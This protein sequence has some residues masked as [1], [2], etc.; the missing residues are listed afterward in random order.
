MKATIHGA[1][2]FTE[3][4]WSAIDR[5]VRNVY[6]K[7]LGVLNAHW[8]T[9]G[10]S[11]VAA[12]LRSWAYSWA[13]THAQEIHDRAHKPA[14]ITKRVQQRLQERVVEHMLARPELP[15]GAGEDF[16]ERV[17]TTRARARKPRSYPAKYWQGR[18]PLE[19]DQTLD[20][21]SLYGY[22]IPPGQLQFIIKRGKRGR[23][24]HDR[25]GNPVTETPEAM[26]EL[27]TRKP[28]RMEF[29]HDVC[30]EWDRDQFRRELA[31]TFNNH[32]CDCHECEQFAKNTINRPA[33]P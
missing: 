12:E 28:T 23:P 15:H 25:H 5:A 27:H 17:R 19:A 9:P 7:T 14:F 10:N 11:D 21:I 18:S 29:W 32:I 6:Y 30:D 26:A 16:E 13:A 4:E 20:S 2:D 1:W 33:N 24:I 8:Q 31:A 3:T 22:T